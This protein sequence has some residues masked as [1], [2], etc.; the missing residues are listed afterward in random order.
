MGYTWQN[1]V[2]QA[3]VLWPLHSQA[4]VG[5]FSQ[6]ED[7]LAPRVRARVCVCPQQP[8]RAGPCH[9]LQAAVPNTGSW[10]ELLRSLGATL[11][12]VSRVPPQPLVGLSCVFHLGVLF[13]KER[14]AS[15]GSQ[16]KGA[17]PG[18]SGQGR[19]LSWGTVPGRDPSSLL[20]SLPPCLAGYLC[21]QNLL[22]GHPDGLEPEHQPN[23]PLRG[24]P[25]LCSP[26][27]SSR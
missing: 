21:P 20:S 13:W 8:R 5:L 27:P 25:H 2:T 9:G 16:G 15:T 3:H 18:P 1:T 7:A 22:R 17:D 10:S 24:L 26:Q 14:A 4:Q 6:S 12:S 11:E 19:P 23:R